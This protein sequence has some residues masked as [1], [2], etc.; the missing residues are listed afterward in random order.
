MKWPCISAKYTERCGVK[1][2]GTIFKTIILRKRMLNLN[3]TEIMETK[4]SIERNAFMI[5]LPTSAL[6]VAYFFTMK[7]LG[8]A[9]ILELR[10]FNFVILAVGIVYGI[11][12]LKK[13]LHQDEFYLKGWAQG[14]YISTVAVV[15]FSVFMCLYISQFDKTLFDHI[16]QNMANSS[17]INAFTLFFS[18]L[19]EGM[20]GCAIITFAAMQYLKEQ[21]S[22][23]NLGKR[24]QQKEKVMEM[25]E[26]RL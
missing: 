23:V 1:I 18:L 9:Q 4:P 26:W 20:A 24:K 11:A 8:L 21:G 5:G 25:E 14:I 6:L 3:K 13:E 10:F 22:N 7:A 2:I 16:R 12:K 19:L 17:S 15:S